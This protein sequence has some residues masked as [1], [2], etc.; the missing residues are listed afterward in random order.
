MVD[1]CQDA[2]LQPAGGA[3]G[4]I[5]GPILDKDRLQDLCAN[6]S[7]AEAREF[8]WLCIVDT[9]LRLADIASHCAAGDLARVAEVA[10]RIAR[11]AANLGALHVYVLALRLETACRNSRSVRTHGLIGELSEA[12]TQAGD[13]MCAWLAGRASL[14]EKAMPARNAA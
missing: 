2:P 7:A 11:E 12:W 3:P 10:H 6:L 5:P 14:P 4:N 9:E 13:T 1:E 8:V